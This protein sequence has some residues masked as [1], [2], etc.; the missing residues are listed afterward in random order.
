MRLPDSLRDCVV[1]VYDGESLLGTSFVVALPATRSPGDFLYAVT[2]RHLVEGSRDLRLRVNRIAS[3]AEFIPIDRSLLWTSDDPRADI[4]VARLSPTN[5]GFQLSTVPMSLVGDDA[6]LDD[7]RVGPGDEVVF[8]GL[9]Q[10]APGTERNLPIARFGQISRMAEEAVPTI[11]PGGTHQ[12]IDAIMVEARSWGGHS[13][14]PAFVLFSATREPGVLELPEWPL[15]D[16]RQIWALLGVVSSHWELPSD[17]RQKN[18]SSSSLEADEEVS[19]NAGIALVVPA[20]KLV[21][22]LNRDDVIAERNE[23]GPPPSV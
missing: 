19:I 5:T 15:K 10:G 20:Q 2:A 22:L 18:R 23:G 12:R 8:V 14:S 6:F 17:V 9:F 4:A 7:R 16:A 1:Y 13:G 11:G 21:D 3:G